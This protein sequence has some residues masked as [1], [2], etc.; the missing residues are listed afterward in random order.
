MN[1]PQFTRTLEN[2]I[3]MGIAIMFTGVEEELDP[4]MNNLI[5][6]NIKSNHLIT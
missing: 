3:R 4:V 5:D 1:D 6:R 2:C